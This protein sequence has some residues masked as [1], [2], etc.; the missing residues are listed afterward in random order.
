MKIAVI[1][2]I[3]SNNYALE[4]VLDDIECVDVDT[5]V[6]TGDIVGYM[7]SPNKVI[8]LLRRY[9]IMCIKGNHD[10]YTMSLKSLSKK[11]FEAIDVKDIQ[12][13]ASAIYTNY[14]LS[15]E[16]RYYLNHLPQSLEM[17][18][19]NYSVLFVHGS[20]R[21]IDEYMYNDTDCLLEISELVENNVIIS[22]HT[23]IPYWKKVNNK[24]IINAGSVGKPKHGNSNA[25]YVI[26]SIEKSNLDVE[27][28]EVSYDVEA[29][30]ND[31]LKNKYFSDKLIDSIDIRP[32]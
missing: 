8:D 2:D 19:G 30:K 13:S 27:I 18:I 28:R 16:N 10:Q 4:K 12:R 7:P 1:S 22:G 11:E 9:K 26:L 23:H 29:M 25:T 6:C 14:V 24:H 17:S 15:D 32:K 3:H 20:P 31:I 5:I 21:A